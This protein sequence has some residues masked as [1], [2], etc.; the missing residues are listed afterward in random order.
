M[1][2]EARCGLYGA[3]CGLCGARCVGIGG[4][5][6]KSEGWSEGIHAREVVESVYDFLNDSS[7]T[8]WIVWWVGRK[9]GLV[10]SKRTEGIAGQGGQR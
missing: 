5:V 10:L 1:G 4:R 2:G 7:W 8:E 6:G 9:Y 3:R